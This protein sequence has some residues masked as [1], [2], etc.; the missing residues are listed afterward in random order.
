FFKI[1]KKP[2]ASRGFSRLLILI[3][4][5]EIKNLLVVIALSFAIAIIM[6]KT[7]I[8]KPSR[9]FQDGFFYG[10]NRYFIPRKDI[11]SQ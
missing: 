11:D 8:K 3:N 5:F 4:Y 9:I 7:E 10:L 2:R 1:I 6:F